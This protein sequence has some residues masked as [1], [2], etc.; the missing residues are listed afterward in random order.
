MAAQKKRKQKSKRPGQKQPQVVQH[1]QDEMPPI[2]TEGLQFFYSNQI[3][4]ATRPPIVTLTFN[5][6]LPDP[7]SDKKVPAR[8]AQ[9]VVEI[10]MDVGFQL[11]GILQNQFLDMVKA[12]SVRPED[13]DL[14]ISELQNQVDQ[15]VELK[16]RVA[17]EE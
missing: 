6:I 13:L 7:A 11:P 12:E 14:L 5:H 3:N 8:Y 9:A 2:R 4:V 10:P 1:V 16:K 15:L 17:K